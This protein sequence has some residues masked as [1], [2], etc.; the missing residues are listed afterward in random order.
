MTPEERDIVRANSAALIMAAM[1][2][3][4]RPRQRPQ[5]DT[6]EMKRVERLENVDRMFRALEAANAADALIAELQARQEFTGN[7]PN[8]VAGLVA[9][10]V[11][12]GGNILSCRHGKASF[13]PCEKCDAE[14][15]ASKSG[16]NGEKK[17]ET[18]KVADDGNS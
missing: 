12:A 7:D 16:A 15:E 8:T 1:H 6:D 11:A 9:A 13:E 17:E 4:W 5:H 14:D 3:N 10:G 2:L 18:G